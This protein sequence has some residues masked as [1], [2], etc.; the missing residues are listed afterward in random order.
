MK[1]QMKLG[2]IRFMRHLAILA[3]IQSTVFCASVGRKT[4]A[5]RSLECV[6]EIGE[7]VLVEGKKPGFAVEVR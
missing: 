7:V 3:L 6:A 2:I 1:G 4:A 5:K